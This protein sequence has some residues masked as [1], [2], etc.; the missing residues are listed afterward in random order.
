VLSGLDCAVHV[1]R[2]CD[3]DVEIEML[4]QVGIWREEAPCSSPWR[5][6]ALLKAERVALNLLQ[7]LVVSPRSPR[8]AYERWKAP[9]P[10]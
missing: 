10:A 5:R 2:A 8:S 4:A 6:R 3:P 9:A 1:L 7:H